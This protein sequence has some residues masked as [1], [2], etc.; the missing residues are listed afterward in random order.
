MIEEAINSLAKVLRKPNVLYFVGITARCK[1]EGL[2]KV[3]FCKFYKLGDGHGMVEIYIQTFQCYDLV[4]FAFHS[5]CLY[6]FQPC[7]GELICGYVNKVIFILTDE[8]DK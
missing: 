5:P 7:L 6:L 2:V 8:L 4:L 3:S 1:L